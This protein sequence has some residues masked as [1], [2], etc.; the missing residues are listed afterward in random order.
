MTEIC[1]VPQR[2]EIRKA[3]YEM[4]S[5]VKRGGLRRKNE[6]RTKKS[7]FGPLVQMKSRLYDHHAQDLLTT[8][9]AA[10]KKINTKWFGWW[11]L[12]QFSIAYRGAN[13]SSVRACTG[14]HGRNEEQHIA[15]VL[16]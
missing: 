4:L 2:S 7:I 10:D 16:V 9:K 1:F 5:M 15:R 8:A 3:E 12:S 11:T 13:D 6:R 14:I